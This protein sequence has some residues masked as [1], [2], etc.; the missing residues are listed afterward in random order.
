MGPKRLEMDTG[1][2]DGERLEPLE[3]LVVQNA[4]IR[5]LIGDP[6]FR[7]I[8]GL[9]VTSINRLC[10]TSIEFRD[11]CNR[12]E[13][14]IYRYLLARDFK[15][16]A[17]LYA[18]ENTKIMYQMRHENT[19]HA[20]IADDTIHLASNASQ[21][22]HNRY[23]IA[24]AGRL[25]IYKGMKAYA[26]R[27]EILIDHLWSVRVNI[28]LKIILI[29]TPENKSFYI[30]DGKTG[31]GVS[32]GRIVKLSALDQN[33]PIRV[34]EKCYDHLYPEVLPFVFRRE[35][36]V[37][38]EEVVYPATGERKIGKMPTTIP[39]AGPGPY[40]TLL[41][42]LPVN[43]PGLLVG[44][45]LAIVESLN[46]LRRELDENPAQTLEI[47]DVATTGDLP[48]CVAIDTRF[49]NS[50]KKALKRSLIYLIYFTFKISG[51]VF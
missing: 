36:P 21:A 20:I 34:F 16:P 3:P 47:V 17:D 13:S 2:E 1:F 38:F 31:F 15:I 40:L 30:T 22:A 51:L 37:L 14:Q 49:L 43:Y 18:N 32:G 12:R 4:E 26:V 42:L 50:Y 25:A 7:I 24:K 9:D 28:C 48:C 11:F 44:V 8:E 10:A 29:D 41:D 39:E 5:D 45:E 35:I 23:N 46:H 27:S 19:H 33:S 6:L